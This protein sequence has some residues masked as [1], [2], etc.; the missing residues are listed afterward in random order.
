MSPEEVQRLVHELQVHQIEL[1]MQNEELRYA[2]ADLAQSR[3]RF[4]D[5][6]DFA[7]VGYLT[8]AHDGTVLE[9]NLTVATMLGVERA[10]LVGRK[11][12]RFVTRAAQDALYLHQCAVLT[13][14]EKQSSEM[15]LRRADGTTFMAR[16]ETIC[17]REPDSP[18]QH[19]RSALIDISEQKRAEEELAMSRR[20]LEVRIVERTAE[21]SCANETLRAILNTVT[22]A[23]FTIDRGGTIL[24][25]NPA[26]QRMFGYGEAEMVGKDV[27]L[28][29][30]SPYREERDR[31]LDNYHRT[32]QA[33]IIGIG[34]EVEARRK[35]GTVFPVELTVSEVAHMDMFTGVIRDITARKRLESEVLRIA[36]EERLHVSADLH[37][38]VCQQLVG[39]SF[40]VN[41]L[42]GD[43]EK[44]C[45]RLVPKTKNIAKA[46]LTATEQTRALARG[47]CPAVID[48]SGLMHALG[49]LVG[50]AA[51]MYRLVCT[52]SCPVPVIVE[53]TTV[54]NELYRIAQEAI[55]NA[56]QHGHAK[57][58]TVRLT[59]C[60]GEICLTVMDNGIGLP[61]DLFRAP[62]MGVRVMTYRA[63]LIGAQLRVQRRRRG[64]TEV[65]CR[66][67]RIPVSP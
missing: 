67:A 26:G 38:G 49:Q 55:R 60:D 24:S 62:G 37:D 45:H 17:F 46:L 34:R 40:L 36:E 28:L 51:K 2:Q 19:C 25:V 3:D 20:D 15:R 54:A 58:V 39:I 29:M 14:A 57:R 44:T 23:I 32:G 61:A 12:G 50:R 47:M 4:N 52:F 18:A 7:P 35:D 5:L 64:G 10:R 33:R 65:I 8:L 6:Y 27:G 1:E 42:R 21:L 43:L 41:S 66:L 53:S 30:P 31:Y 56:H 48:S 13:Q 22:D 63:G 9:A 11:F 59:E 16:M